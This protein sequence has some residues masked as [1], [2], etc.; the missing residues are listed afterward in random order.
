MKKTRLAALISNVMIGFNHD[1]Y[2]LSGAYFQPL[3]KPKAKGRHKANS[4]LRL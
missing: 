3:G 2:Q 1:F 4:S